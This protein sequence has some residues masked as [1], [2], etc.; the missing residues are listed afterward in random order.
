MI[1]QTY[2]TATSFGMF[3]PGEEYAGLQMKITSFGIPQVSAAAVEQGT[4]VL[5]AKHAASRVKFEPLRVS[6]LSDGGLSNIKPVHN[7]L[8]NNVIENDTVTKD[9]RVIG[10][11][12]SE[13]PVF[14]VDFHDAFPT[15][16]DIDKFDSMDSTD[17]LIKAQLEFAYDLYTYG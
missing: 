7:W 17:A 4:R 6:V 12:A 2:T 3:I 10:Y 13:V 14:T 9:I 5:Q 11:S 15:S 8:I 16:I 1:N